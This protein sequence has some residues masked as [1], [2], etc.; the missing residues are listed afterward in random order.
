[1]AEAG[2]ISDWF[3]PIGQD[4]DKGRMDAVRLDKVA[5][6]VLNRELAI[7][8]EELAKLKLFFRVLAEKL[9]I[10]L[11]WFNFVVVGLKTVIGLKHQRRREVFQQRRKK[12]TCFFSRVHQ[13]NLCYDEKK[14]KQTN[15]KQKHL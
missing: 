10:L 4:V 14:N 13:R 12:K 6:V 8:Q 3:P 15:K 5:H 7:A 11:N 2:K 9:S 1:M